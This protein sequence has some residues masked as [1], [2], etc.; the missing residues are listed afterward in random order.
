ME[1]RLIKKRITNLGSANSG[2]AAS[3]AKELG[4]NLGEIHLGQFPDGETKI[5][6]NDPIRG[7]DV[8]VIQ[9]RFY[10]FIS[11]GLPLALTRHLTEAI[12]RFSLH[13]L[14]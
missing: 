6:I 5:E 9:V 4:Q 13:A 10:Y 8:F 12:P 14:R 1:P 3:I 7:H 11:T 2:L